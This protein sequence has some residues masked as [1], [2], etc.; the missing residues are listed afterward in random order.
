MA[1]NAVIRQKALNATMTT[2][3]LAHGK[4][5]DLSSDAIVMGILNMTPDSFSDG[6]QNLEDGRALSYARTMISEGAI[7]VDVGGESTRPGAQPIAQ[8]VE[9]LRI[10]PVIK[11]LAEKTEALI[12]IDSYHAKTALWA[13]NNGAHIIND[14]NGLQ[15]EPEMAEVVA[16]TNAAVIIM[17]NSRART[18]SDDVIEHQKYFFDRSLD[19]A[20]SKGIDPQK[21]VLDPGFG[22]GKEEKEN[23]E[24][25]KR[26]HELLSFGFPL[27]A[28]TSRKRFLGQFVK[29]DHPTCRD[30]A[31]AASSVI[32]RHA[33]FSIFR[34]HNVEMN[35][36]ALKLADAVQR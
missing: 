13:V 30:V 26:A 33:G 5:L 7:I 24:L 14:I 16:E 27:L 35:R 10:L 2:W 11:D 12:S 34:V 22:F 32:L 20:N 3:K 9:Q 21:I 36:Q 23:I 19:I 18:K 4:Q 1:Q 17:H 28:G 31:T 8:N 15:G 25:L 29:P 6:G